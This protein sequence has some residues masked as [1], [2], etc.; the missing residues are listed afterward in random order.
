MSIRIVCK[1]CG[2]KIDAKEE[3]RG[4]IRRCPKCHTPILV[5]PESMTLQMQKHIA[6]SLTS[7]SLNL[8]RLN[9]DNLYVVLGLD[10]E[11]AF[12]K[13]GDGWLLNVGCGFES[14]R[15]V[16]EK[17]PTS[18]T[19]VLVEGYV[20]NT[21]LG[22]RLKGIRCKKLDGRGVLKVLLFGE[23]SEILERA[24][25]PAFLTSVQKRILLQHIRT[26]YFFDFTDSAPEIVDF[27]T[28]FDSHTSEIGTFKN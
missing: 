9:P 21:E 13:S 20:E 8:K 26:H 4:Q 18:G 11:I 7:N 27:L 1:N 14:I 15:R 25:E 24:K 10:R 28:G 12:W 17:L 23:A 2:S 16:P 22:H 3:L 5:V 19:F 6:E